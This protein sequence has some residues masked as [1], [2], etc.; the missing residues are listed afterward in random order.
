VRV[1]LI[2]AFLA[3][4]GSLALAAV[5][6]ADADPAPGESVNITNNRISLTFGEAVIPIKIEVIDAKG[7]DVATGQ[8]DGTDWD[9]DVL[10]K[11]P[12]RKGYQCGTMTV[13]WHVKV[14]AD[15]REERGEYSFTARPHHSAHCH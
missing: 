5:R 8:T 6:L 7:R 3:L 14:I 9:I 11:A 10:M 12:E 4:Q 1:S 15:G 2:L 13:R